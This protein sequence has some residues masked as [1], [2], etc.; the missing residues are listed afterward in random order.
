MRQDYTIDVARW[1]HVMRFIAN[2][3]IFAVISMPLFSVLNMIWDKRIGFSEEGE[4]YFE[5]FAFT[6]LALLSLVFAT[7]VGIAKGV[8]TSIYQHP[9]LHKDEWLEKMRAEG[10]EQPKKTSKK[11]AVANVASGVLRGTKPIRTPPPVDGTIAEG[12]RVVRGACLTQ[13]PEVAIIKACIEDQVKAAKALYDYY[14]KQGEAAVVLRNRFSG[15]ARLAPIHMGGCPLPWGYENTGIFIQGSAGAGKTQV[16]KQMM[17]DARMRGGRDKLVVYDRKPEFLDFLWRD[18]DPIICPADRRHTRWDVFAEINGEQD[19]DNFVSSLMPT[20]SGGGGDNQA[21]WN[22]SAK[23]VLKGILFFLM[24]ADDYDFDPAQKGRILSEQEKAE[25][26]PIFRN[27]KDEYTGLMRPS[28]LDLCKLLYNTLATPKEL[29]GLLQ[30]VPIA[31]ASGA[32]LKD[33]G[34]SQGGIASSVLATLGQFTA[35]FTLPEVAE[36]GWLSV[37][38]WLVDPATDGQAMFLVNPANYAARYQSYYTVVLDLMLKEM[39]S[40]PTDITRRV[41]F[42]IDEFGSLFKLDSVIRLLAEGRSKG[43]CTVIGVQDR[44]Q[45]KGQYQ[46]EVSTLLNN[47]NSKVIGRVVDGEE[48]GTIAE[49]DIGKFEVV[50]SGGNISMS[51]SGKND[52][53]DMNLSEDNKQNRELRDTVMSAQIMQL[54]GLNYL[55]K[56]SSNNWFRWAMP[57][58]NWNKHSICPAFLSKGAKAF[59]SNGLIYQES[60]KERLRFDLLEEQPKGGAPRPGMPQRQG[61]MGGMPGAIGAMGMGAKP[62]GAAGTTPPGSPF[63]G[64]GVQGTGSGLMPSAPGANPASEAIK[65]MRDKKSVARTSRRPRTGAGVGADS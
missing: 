19:I 57:F 59:E 18:N 52:G 50:A 35:S 37:R 34:K 54:P 42:F 40:I 33:A 3:V 28:N 17:W 29:W 25:R 43:A 11:K 22:S 38:K 16:I 5:F 4:I 24:Y 12:E 6:D 62:A 39:I 32:P 10:V 49:K 27:T 44:A 60:E 48:A 1:K 13:G 2:Y 64:A 47:C 55:M 63:G 8:S 7:V 23:Q 51:I 46:D 14:D 20:P 65:N 61:G 58:Y 15:D 41:W 45:L 56:F 31:E 36:P 30:R 21:F 9:F 53:G 26:G